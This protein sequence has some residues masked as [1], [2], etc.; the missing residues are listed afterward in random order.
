M[1][2]LLSQSTTGLR[3]VADSFYANFKQATLLGENY[4]PIDLRSPLPKLVYKA[5]RKISL[6]PVT[7]THLLKVATDLPSPVLSNNALTM[8][9]GSDGIIDSIPVE[10]NDLVEISKSLAVALGVSPGTWRF[11]DKRTLNLENPPKYTMTSY[12]SI[13]ERWRYRVDA[14]NGDLI[15]LQSVA[16][17]GVT[18]KNN[19]TAIRNFAR[20]VDGNPYSYA[21]ASDASNQSSTVN[22]T[23]IQHVRRLAMKAT[24]WKTAAD[25]S[26]PAAQFGIQDQT[27]SPLGPLF[28]NAD[29]GARQVGGQVLWARGSFSYWVSDDLDRT[30]SSFT[31]NDAGSSR[32]YTSLEILIDGPC[33]ILINGEAPTAG[34]QI[35]I[36]DY[37]ASALRPSILSGDYAVIANSGSEQWRLRKV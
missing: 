11:T 23:P 32:S 25:N 14:E 5:H 16:A 24:S 18:V 34:S 7:L 26:I 4:R 31:L 15:G 12:G 27:L 30:F 9:I 33:Q 20:L 3:I 13:G 28:T 1:P 8:T 29:T 19:S 17:S 21:D 2:K 6:E 37:V 22:F 35:T 36:P 10:A